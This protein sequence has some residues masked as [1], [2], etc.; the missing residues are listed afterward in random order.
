MSAISLGGGA[1][2]LSQLAS[3]FQLPQL[4]AAG[5]AAPGGIQPLT[6][7]QLQSLG[8][9]LGAGGLGIPLNSLPPNAISAGNGGNFMVEILF[10]LVK[11]E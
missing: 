6:L 7:Q 4:A 2:G 10:F 9:G 1:A 8:L 11:F 5:G 3:A